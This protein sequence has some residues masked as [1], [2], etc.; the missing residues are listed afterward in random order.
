[1]AEL[2]SVDVPWPLIFLG[3]I[4]VLLLWLIINYNQ[5]VRLRL[6][7]AESWSGIDTE[8]KRR[9]DLIPRLVE[10]VKGYARHERAVIEAVLQARDQAASTPGSPRTQAAAENAL[11]HEMRMVLGVIDRYPELKAGEHFLR[12]Q[13]ELSNTEDRIQ[14]ARRFYNGNVRDLNTCIEGFPSNLLA[15]CLGVQ[16][17]EFFEVEA[18]LAADSPAV[19]ATR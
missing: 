3:V 9:H 14:A 11:V 16:R 13:H 18:A 19:S 7:V 2:Q 5:L 1:M 6:H 17:A 4:G 10:T 15:R 8:L 12:L